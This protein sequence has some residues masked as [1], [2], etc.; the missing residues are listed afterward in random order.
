[1]G[2][3]A[4]YHVLSLIENDPSFCSTGKR[5]QRPVAHQLAAYL[6][7]MGDETAK[8]AGDVSG[9]AEGTSYIYTSRVGKA[10][11]R[12]HHN[13]LAWPGPTRKAEHK[14]EMAED[15]FPGCVG[16][17]DGSLFFLINKPLVS[18][19]SYFGRKKAYCAS[20]YMNTVGVRLLRVLTSFLDCHP[21]HR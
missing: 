18:G 16:E 4:F 3:A 17:G 21:D 5:P 20:C 15:G 6:I 19:E 1:M 8:K 13:H 9:I 10:L 7:R 11:R 14:A 12:I 2:R